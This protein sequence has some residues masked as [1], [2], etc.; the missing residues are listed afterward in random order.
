MSPKEICK[1]LK[2]NKFKI[3]N[4]QESFEDFVA[5]V[6]IEKKII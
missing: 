6:K 1:N 3:M 5:N 2:G 4:R